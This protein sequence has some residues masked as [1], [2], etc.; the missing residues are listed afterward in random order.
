MEVNISREHVCCRLPS[1]SSWFYPSHA[2]SSILWWFDGIIIW[3]GVLIKYMVWN[4]FVIVI[5]QGYHVNSVNWVIGC[6]DT[7]H[8]TALLIFIWH[9]DNKLR[10]LI[11]W[12]IKSTGC[13]VLRNCFAYHF[14]T[15]ADNLHTYKKK[16]NDFL[17]FH[18]NFFAHCRL[19]NLFLFSSLFYSFTEQTSLPYFGVKLSCVCLNFA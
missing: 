11:Q 8:C 15:E 12:I 16:N 3:G 10:I 17:R 9:N 5:L 6:L 14:L 7:A 2:E 4:Q 13:R 18:K 1:E 19:N